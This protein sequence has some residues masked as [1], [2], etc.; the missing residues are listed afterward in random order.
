VFF[1]LLLT[2]NN[3]QTKRVK[4][5][6]IASPPKR[7]YTTK[8]VNIPN[9][10]KIWRFLQLDDTTDVTPISGSNAATVAGAYY[11]T[12]NLLSNASSFSSLFDMYKV[13]ALQIEIVPRFNAIALTTTSN[14]PLRTVI[15]YDDS[16]V[17]ASA[18]A[19]EQYSSCISLE[20]HES[21]LRVFQPRIAVAA[22]SGA[23]TSYKSEASDWIDVA[24]NTVRHYG[25]K[26]YIPVSPTTS[27]PVWDLKIRVFLAFKTVR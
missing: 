14:S 22:Y 24:S 20:A 19:A 27:V 8:S 11:F 23:F 16:T 3:K 10:P 15:D 6:D 7:T 17:L 4:K 26:W 12:L 2:K 13:E 9:V 21:C 5:S 1:K 25:I 18:A